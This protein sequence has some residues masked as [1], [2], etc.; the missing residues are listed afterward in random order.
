MGHIKINQIRIYLIKNVENC[1]GTCITNFLSHIVRKPNPSPIIKL[2]YIRH[3]EFHL[4][5]SLGLVVLLLVLLFK[6]SLQL[7][8]PVLII[9][10][11]L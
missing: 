9:Q 11:P 1:I 3:D 6:Q 4:F 10:R 2:P 8:K 5:S 7:S